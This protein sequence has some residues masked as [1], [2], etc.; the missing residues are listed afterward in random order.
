MTQGVVTISDE[1]V[2]DCANRMFASLV[3]HSLEEVGGVRLRD[4]VKSVDRPIFDTILRQALEGHSNGHD[5]R[6]NAGKGD[7]SVEMSM[8]TLWRETGTQISVVVTEITAL[9]QNE[10][11]RLQIQAELEQRICTLS[12]AYA[13]LSQISHATMYEKEAHGLF[14]AVCRIA[15]E[16]GRFRMAWI[17]MLDVESQTVTPVASAGTTAGYLEQVKINLQDDSCN[18][19]PTAQALVTGQ[20]KV[21]ND[22]R[23][24]RS[25]ERWRVEMVERGYLSSAAFPLMI[26]GK[27]VGTLNLYSFEENS[28]DEEELGLLAELTR[29]ISYAL[30]VQQLERQRLR[31]DADLRASEERFRELAETIQDMFWIMD[32]IDRRTLYISPASETILGRSCKSLYEQPDSWFDAVHPDDQDRIRRAVGSLVDGD[33]YDIEY[34]IIRSD[35]QVRMIHDL[36]YPVRDEAGQLLRIVGVAR[37]ITEQ[38]S[39]EDQLRQSQKMDAV[40]Q[41]AGGVAHDFNNIL[42][43][44]IMQ[45]QLTEAT[46]E[47]PDKVRETLHEIR[48]AADRAANL[49]RQL[50][51]FGRRQV[52]QPSDVDL[53]GIVTQLTKMLERI[54]GEDVRL[55]LDL[56]AEPLM[57]RADPGMLEQLLMNLSVNARDAMPQGG[58]LLIESAK[59]CV[60]EAELSRNP[61][62]SAGSHVWLSVSDEGCGMS[63]ETA[64]RA[65]EPFFTTKE[66]GRGTG[67]GLAT[68]FG[69][70]KQHKGWINVTSEPEHGTRIEVFLPS[71]TAGATVEPLTSERAQENSCRGNETVLVVEDEPGVRE[72]VRTVLERN[73]YR[74]MEAANGAD[75]IRLVEGYEGA[76]D[77]LLTDIVMP[78]GLNGWDL[79]RRLLRD[80]PQL[81]VLYFSGY[82]A[83][84]A[85]RKIELSHQETFLQK[86]LSADVLLEAV[87]NCLDG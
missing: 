61:A 77:L 62:A 83:E 19:G 40:G 31:A 53:N 32:P 17:G 67:L 59:R 24:D 8:S 1:G 34:R 43:I 58:R 2:I 70:V 60:D 76:L 48:A 50:L 29:D 41:L 11:K 52:I 55:E 12:R 44:I 5:L 57:T 6:L 72:M 9:K 81:K 85:E 38:R 51:L 22:V 26:G 13:M 66:V 63:P 23:S 49:T 46:V 64:S 45:A 86:P 39:L 4:F 14:S 78:G 3:G 37:D 16:D 10:G 35:E 25:V 20:Y 71:G 36:A 84:I 80:D 56:C 68:V 18:R 82:S 27:A 15:V 33:E 47:L 42:S 74:V 21:C 54:I 7:T 28:F 30:E 73:G 75:A 65:F 69:I 87:R 79:G